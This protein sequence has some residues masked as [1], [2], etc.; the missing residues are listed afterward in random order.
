MIITNNISNLSL[1]FSFIQGKSH[2]IV[3]FF[4]VL[5]S[6]LTIHQRRVPLFDFG[7]DDSCLLSEKKK[8]LLNSLLFLY[9]CK[10]INVDFKFI[11]NYSN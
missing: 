4:F 10:K 5:F 11:S 6:S 2:L 8:L 7:I 3:I 9:V 1:A